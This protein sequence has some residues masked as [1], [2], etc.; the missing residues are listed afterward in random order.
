MSYTWSGPQASLIAPTPPTA[1]FSLG[2][3]TDV[4]FGSTSAHASI[5]VPGRVA[6]ISGDLVLV[7]V[8]HQG[9]CTGLWLHRLELPL[10]L[11]WPAGQR[12]GI[13]PSSPLFPPLRGEAAGA[14]PPRQAL[15][16][17]W[18]RRNASAS[19]TTPLALSS[20]APPHARR[21]TL[22]TA[23]FRLPPGA[24]APRQPPEP[25][26]DAAA[27]ARFAAFVAALEVGQ[28]VV[29]QEAP[30]GEWAP[31]LVTALHAEPARSGIGRGGGPVR[32][33]VVALTAVREG[34]GEGAGVTLH[35]T[36]GRVAPWEGEGEGGAPPT[37]P[38]PPAAPPPAASAACCALA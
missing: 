12:S 16:A 18:S 33:P 11:S 6:A 5:W 31:A 30:G 29:V 24:L 26:V 7:D 2:A 17:A 10:R 21:A 1:R 8:R 27:V 4:L 22:G 28:R 34:G 35:L 25:E 15:P 3:P 23:D 36:S 14:A 37:T 20:M 32:A 19:F 13:P 38:P 9:A